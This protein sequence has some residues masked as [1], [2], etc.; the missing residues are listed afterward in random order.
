MQA[1]RLRRGL[2]GY[3]G[4]SVRL[5]L[6]V[7]DN[8][9]AKTSE[10]ALAM[11]SRAAQLTA[12]LER[13]GAEAQQ[14]GS[15]LRTELD[16]AVR[17]AEGTEATL[18]R[19]EALAEELRFELAASRRLFLR[20]VARA[21]SL[22]ASLEDLAARLW[23]ARAELEA[24]RGPAGALSPGPLIVLPDLDGKD[25]TAPPGQVSGATTNGRLPATEPA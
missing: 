21:R 13:L 14:E 11:E 12:E 8:T 19:R 22:E 7:R 18:A 9:L 25:A 6:A 4:R 16:A 17:R 10:R 23:Q 3:S 2:F 15:A 24:A 20:Q 1:P 5:A